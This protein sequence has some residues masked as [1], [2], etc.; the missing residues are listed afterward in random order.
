MDN[1]KRSAKQDEHKAMVTIDG[2]GINLI[3]HAEDE[4]EYYAL[5][6][7][8]SSNLGSDTDVTSCSKVCEASY[9]KLKKLY[10]EQ[11]EQLGVA[12]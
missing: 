8:N 7:F 5:M 9:A 10:D 2:K 6:A 3:G 4:T 1:G 11:R 12:I